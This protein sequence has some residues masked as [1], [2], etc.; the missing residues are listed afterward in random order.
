MTNTVQNRGGGNSA[1]NQLNLG[2]G[3][4]PNLWADFPIA[5]IQ[6]GTRDG[7]YQF[8]DF[9]ETAYVVPTTEGNYGNG[10]KGFSST[11]GV[12]TTTG[13][14]ATGA[15]SAWGVLALG[16]DGDDEGASL[17]KN[18]APFK[19]AGPQTTLNARTGKLVFEA[20]CKV[21]SIGDTISDFFFGLCEL[22]TLTAT[23]PI[24]ATGG[25][26]ADK[27]FVGFHR[28]G[29]ARTVAGTGGA[30][31]NATYKTDGNAV[32]KPFTD[33]LTLVADTWF[34]AGMVYDPLACLL[35]FF[36]NGISC[37]TG[38]SLVSTAGNPFPNDINL[39]LTIA[40]LNAAAGTPT[41]SC[42][43][44]ACGQLPA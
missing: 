8:D 31:I 20:R 12:M 29:T 16:S 18:N 6:N 24:T 4:S 10:W 1:N 9:L 3:L 23:V 2:R 28:P 15:N 22:T 13:S 14:D 38:Y 27:N 5:E 41:C 11:G 26:L 44:I 21:S 30:I 35:T 25:T 39:A 43:W 33:A 37:G 42:D 19:L 34:K 7:V 17:Q 32:V 36:V 40:T